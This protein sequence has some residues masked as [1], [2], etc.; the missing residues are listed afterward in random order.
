MHQNLKLKGELSLEGI[1]P[2]QGDNVAQRLN[3][4]PVPIPRRKDDNVFYASG[5]L[6][7]SLRLLSKINEG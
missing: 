1:G 5:E 7:T 4:K 6:T 3:A 2:K